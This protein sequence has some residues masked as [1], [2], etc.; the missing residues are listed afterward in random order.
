MVVCA[1]HAFIRLGFMFY[2]RDSNYKICLIKELL[3]S[4]LPHFTW[5]HVEIFIY[6]SMGGMTTH[7]QSGGS[8]CAGEVWAHLVGNI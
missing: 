5:R 6:L 7:C 4:S 8:D 3:Q 1:L 2:L